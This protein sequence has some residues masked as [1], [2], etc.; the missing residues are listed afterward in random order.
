MSIIYGF[1]LQ[2]F[3]WVKKFFIKRF[4]LLF[5]E[6]NFLSPSKQLLQLLDPTQKFFFGHLFF[7]SFPPQFPIN[8]VWRFFYQYQSFFLIYLTKLK[9]WAHQQSLSFSSLNFRD[10]FYQNLAYL[11]ELGAY[12]IFFFFIPNKTKKLSI[13]T[14]FQFSSIV[15]TEL[16]GF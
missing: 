4:S 13:L 15:S 2:H 5:V 6:S 16:K 11:M 8:K 12:I 10:I 3:S 9:S 1:S 14:I 7:M